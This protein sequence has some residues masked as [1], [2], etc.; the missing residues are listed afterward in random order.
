MRFVYLCQHFPPET[1]APQIRV[2][3]VSREL[4]RRGHQ[5][6]VVT[7][8]PHRGDPSMRTPYRGRFHVSEKWNGITVHRYWISTSTG[9]NARD[10]ISSYLSFT[11]SSLCA[12]FSAGPSD[13][14]ICNSPPL[15]LGVTGYIIARLTG[16]RFVF[17][18]AD[19][20]PQSAIDLGVLKN[21]IIILLSEKLERWL[22]RRA[23]AV[24]AA[25]DGIARHVIA[26]GKAPEA[27]FLLLNGADTEALRPRDRD[28]GLSRELGLSGKRVFL[29]AG[30]MG[31]AQGLDS[32][33]E[34]ARLLEK[35]HPEVYFLFLGD[36]V[37]KEALK[38]LC[39]EM[40]LCNAGFHDAVPL[41]EVSQ[42][43]SCAD[44][45]IVPLK[46][47]DLFKG[48]RPSKIFTALATGTPVLYC[49]EGESADIIREH[50]CGRVAP[51]ENAPEIARVVSQLCA[52]P[53]T[54]Y[55]ELCRNARRVAVDTFS[56]R[57]SVNKLLEG[58]NVAEKAR[59]RTRGCTHHPSH[60]M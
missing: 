15:T 53:A 30:N 48:A 28:E 50:R 33:L 3:E 47:I 14:L 2:S 13:F 55:D 8:F 31:R 58:L 32:I 51:P 1:G 43:F 4:M 45:S 17:N 27:V 42:Y 18:V 38:R 57:N 41:S 10:R 52:L 25:T 12:L 7:A 11:L 24:A 60:R 22:Y 20:W 36:G 34:A 56:W 23:F 59:G 29:Y 49:G 46:N 6:T 9:G 40:R 37:E 16:A 21:R 5:V 44:Y 39:V 54:E 19:V 35:D 26:K